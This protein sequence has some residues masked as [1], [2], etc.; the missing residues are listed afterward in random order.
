MDPLTAALNLANTVSNGLIDIFKA[1]P[2]AQ[3]A[4]VANDIVT[5]LHNVV[6][7]LTSVQ[8]KI[9]AAVAK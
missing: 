7:F 6:A 3:Q 1:L 5:P 2:A 8:D 9:N 4:T